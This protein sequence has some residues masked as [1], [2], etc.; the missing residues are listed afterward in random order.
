MFA[1]LARM[2]NEPSTPGS[3]TESTCS[4]ST[5]RSG[6]MMRRVSGPAMWD[7]LGR[8]AGRGGLCRL[9][10]LGRLPAALELLRARDDGVD[11][12]DH[13]EGL[14]GQGVVH[15]LGDLLE[16][17]HGV[18]ARDEDAGRAG[19]LLGH[20]EGLRQEALDAARASDGELVLVRELL[21]AEDR[22]DVLEV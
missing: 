5:M 13:V 9:R 2:P 21:D 10:T 6:E 3:R 14:L 16:G 22:D 11:V 17:A 12:A 4:S 18:L 15:A 20:E 1:C 19:E 8:L 7:S